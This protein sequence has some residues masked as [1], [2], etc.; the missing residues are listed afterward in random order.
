M[1]RLT[2]K[3]LGEEMK[4]QGILL[5]EVISREEMRDYVTNMLFNINVADSTDKKIDVESL[6]ERNVRYL[7]IV[8]DKLNRFGGRLPQKVEEE[9]ENLLGFVHWQKRNKYIFDEVGYREFMSQQWT[10]I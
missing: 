2:V 10:K 7:Y 8:T 1:A 6:I 9:V 4:S 3:Q 5:D